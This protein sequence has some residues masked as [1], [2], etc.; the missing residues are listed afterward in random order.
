MSVDLKYIDGVYKHLSAM[1]VSLDIDPIEFG[2]SR[3][4]NK[5]VQVRSFL[6][7]TE[8]TF[9]EVSQNLHKYKRDLLV[10]ET[11]YNL[12]QTQL[13]ATDPHVRSGRSQQEREAQM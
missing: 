5:I 8:K 7:K 2:P 1:D 12:E 13:M 4:N 3:L 6:S 11:Q 9:M 10:S